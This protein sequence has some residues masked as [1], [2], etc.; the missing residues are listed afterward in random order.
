[1]AASIATPE[2][3]P[4]EGRIEEETTYQLGRTLSVDP[5]NECFVGE[6]S[7]A[8]NRLLSRPYR[9][10]FAVPEKV[11]ALAEENVTACGNKRTF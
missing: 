10:P 11:Q 9:T 5:A 2:P 7:E 8:A 3:S 6:R 1:M 4:S